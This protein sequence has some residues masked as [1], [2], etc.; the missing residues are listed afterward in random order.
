MIA[1]FSKAMN[2]EANITEGAVTINFGGIG[3][4]PSVPVDLEDFFVPNVTDHRCSVAR[5]DFKKPIN[6]VR[7]SVALTQNA[8]TYVTPDTWGKTRVAIEALTPSKEIEAAD[9]GA[10]EGTGGL[11]FLSVSQDSHAA[12]GNYSNVQARKD[13]AAVFMGEER[14][15][16]E[17]GWKP[18]A[19]S[20]SPD[21]L[22]GIVEVITAARSEV[23]ANAGH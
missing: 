18:Q 21:D 10:G 1:A 14:F 12:N 23:L 13:W 2:F 6:P 19:V 17:L 22:T 8:M 4:D 11:M 7:I 16:V 5:D 20:P 15:P 9:I 3:V